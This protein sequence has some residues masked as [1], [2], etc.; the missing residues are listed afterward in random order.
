[1]QFKAKTDIFKDRPW[2]WQALDTGNLDS[3]TFWTGG[4]SETILSTVVKALQIIPITSADSERN[5]SIR[6]AIHSKVRNR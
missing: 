2:V 1:M 5:W 4:F 3:L 6:G